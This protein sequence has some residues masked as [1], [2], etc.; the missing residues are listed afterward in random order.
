MY[1]VETHVKDKVSGGFFL[2]PFICN[3][4]K[5]TSKKQ[6]LENAQKLAGQ[7]HDRVVVYHSI[8]TAPDTIVLDIRKDNA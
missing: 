4:T 6:A 7:G 3:H 2:V 5:Y 1:I 8:R